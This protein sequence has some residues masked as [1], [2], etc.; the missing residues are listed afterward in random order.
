MSSTK[1]RA[2][3]RS[4]NPSDSMENFVHNMHIRKY[5]GFAAVEPV[6]IEPLLARRLEAIKR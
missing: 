2:P 3:Q 1:T 6:G 5:Q 4:A